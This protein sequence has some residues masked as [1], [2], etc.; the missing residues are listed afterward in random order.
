MLFDVN[1]MGGAC[2]YMV[3]IGFTEYWPT[4]GTFQITLNYTLEEIGDKKGFF[5]YDSTIYKFLTTEE[6]DLFPTITQYWQLILTVT[7]LTIYYVP[8]ICISLVINLAYENS[9]YLYSLFLDYIITT[10]LLLWDPNK[11][12]DSS[13]HW[14]LPAPADGSTEQ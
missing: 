6:I 3:I 7:I 11:P 8:L 10:N 5:D 12:E 14:Q 4:E 1:Y 9:P 13:D 2:G